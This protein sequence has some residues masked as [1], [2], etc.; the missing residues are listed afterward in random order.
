[1]LLEDAMPVL[2]GNTPELQSTHNSFLKSYDGGGQVQGGAL[3]VIEDVDGKFATLP[4]S[5]SESIKR[6]SHG[7]HLRPPDYWGGENTIGE[8]GSTVWEEVGLI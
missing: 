7:H 1:M 4:S 6:S 2:W 5:Q 3:E 8:G